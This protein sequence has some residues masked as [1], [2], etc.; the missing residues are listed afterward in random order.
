MFYVQNHPWGKVG[1]YSY[2]IVLL[3]HGNAVVVF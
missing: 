1:E 2:V 3:V